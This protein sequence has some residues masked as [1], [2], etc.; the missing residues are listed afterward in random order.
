MFVL[1]NGK[2][3]E[4]PLP[5]MAAT[6]VV[7][8]VAADVARQQPLHELAKC[9]GSGGLQNQMEVVGHKAEGKDFHAMSGLSKGKQL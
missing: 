3:F 9:R 6:A 7:A 8:M 5:D 1:L 4:P 2:T